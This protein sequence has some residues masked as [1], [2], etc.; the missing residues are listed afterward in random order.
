M[1]ERIWIGTQTNLLP[2]LTHRMFFI[3][4]NVHAKED[5][6]GNPYYNKKGKYKTFVLVKNT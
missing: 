5:T 1:A 6:A 4:E 2:E 3:P